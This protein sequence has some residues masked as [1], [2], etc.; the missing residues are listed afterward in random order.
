[1]GPQQGEDTIM[2]D[3]DQDENASDRGKHVVVDTTPINSPVR[4]ITG[5]PSSAIPPAVQL[6]LEEM[7]AEMKNDLAEIKEEIKHEIDELRADMRVDMNASGEA[8]S[9]KI[10]EMMTF[11]HKLAN[12][13]NKP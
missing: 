1:M 11:L 9:K 12:Q 4:F 13:L 7:K 2:L 8:T 6:A 3:Q 10:D 5:S